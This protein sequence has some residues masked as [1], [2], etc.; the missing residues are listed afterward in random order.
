MQDVEPVTAAAAHSPEHPLEAP[1]EA[2]IMALYLCLVLG[3]E[4]IAVDDRVHRVPS[5][6]ELIWSTTL[7]LAVAHL[8][9]FGLVSHI[10]SGRHLGREAAIAMVWQ[11]LAA[12]VIATASS[13]PSHF[14]M[15][16]KRS[17]R[18]RS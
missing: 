7:G 15:F 4:F 14:S 17:T 12:I 1:R 10:F 2:T 8:F 16:R 18:M 13:I 5:A 3:A 6:I 9:T 11:L